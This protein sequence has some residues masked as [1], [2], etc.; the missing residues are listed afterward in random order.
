MVED[1]RAHERLDLVED[2]MDKHLADHARFELAIA[3][4]TELTKQIAENTSELVNIVK[5]AKGLRSFVIWAAPIAA[6]VAA[7]W[8]FFKD[9]K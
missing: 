8:A 3:E 6:A 1:R 4:N 5:G 9:V 7:C 2:K